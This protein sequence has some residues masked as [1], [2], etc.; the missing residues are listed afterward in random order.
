MGR[1]AIELTVRRAAALVPRAS[2]PRIPCLI[3][4]YEVFLIVFR[5]PVALGVSSEGACVARVLHSVSHCAARAGYF[6]GEKLKTNLAKFHALG[7]YGE[8][9][10]E[11]WVA[12]I[13]R[14]FEVRPTGTS[15]ESSRIG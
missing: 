2:A 6:V 13:T 11:V 14:R 3:I 8:W 4:K 10:K 15:R 9:V 7:G 12:H 5:A 1:R